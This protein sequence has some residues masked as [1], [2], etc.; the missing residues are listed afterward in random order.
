[1]SREFIYRIRSIKEKKYI[2][3]GSLYGV[4][5]VA[6]LTGCFNRNEHIIEEYTGLDDING[7]RIFE[8]DILYFTARYK[9]KGNVPVIYYGGSFGCV[10]TDDSDF[11]ELWNLSHIVQQYYPKIVGTIYDNDLVP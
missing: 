7:N 6:H 1:M 2:M 5:G 11:K 10:V 8:N 3:T 4:E 9:Q